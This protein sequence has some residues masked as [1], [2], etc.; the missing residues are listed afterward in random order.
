MEIRE[1]TTKRERRQAVPILQQLWTE[2]SVDEILAWTGDDEYHLFGGFLEDGEPSAGADRGDDELVVV[3]G[4]LVR[5]VLHHA[6]HAWLYDLVVDE[7]RRGQ[8]YGGRIVDHVEAW[9]DDRG[10]E[11]VALVTPLPED[12]TNEFYEQ[13]DYDT[14][15]HVLEKEL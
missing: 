4:V 7:P 6:R 8:G 3:A 12:D 2:K 15:G 14:W 10:C 5:N 1:L 13:Q 11:Y 9:A